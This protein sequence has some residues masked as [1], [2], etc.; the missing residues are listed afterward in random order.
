[1]NREEMGDVKYAVVRVQ[2]EQRMIDLFTLL[3]SNG[4]SD[5]SFVSSLAH[6]ILKTDTTP[7]TE[8]PSTSRV[9][10]SSSSAAARSSNATAAAAAVSTTTVELQQQEP[11]TTPQQQPPKPQQQQGRVP[12]TAED[13]SFSS[14]S[15]TNAADLLQS[16]FERN[17]EED[18]NAHLQMAAQPQQWI[19]ANGEIPAPTASFTAQPMM[20][21]IQLI[22]GGGFGAPEFG[23][24][25]ISNRSI[26]YAGIDGTGRKMPFNVRMKGWQRKILSDAMANG[27]PV[28]EELK[29]LCDSAQVTEVQ[30]IRF[31]RKRRYGQAGDSSFPMED[32]GDGMLSNSP[33]GP[34][35]P[36][37]HL[38]KTEDIE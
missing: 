35:P 20:M 17:A 30:A 23:G 32:D 31:F 21:P 9:S 29:V 19:L 1:V 15:K 7:A 33:E 11:P 28:G 22:P 13:E 38:P 3:V 6:T 34:A 12:K 18:A 27:V 8:E 16:L 10:S 36:P 2:G 26:N 37:F 24:G 14:P 5:V 4:Y 25:P